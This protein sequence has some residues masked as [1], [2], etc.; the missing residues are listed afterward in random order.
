MFII[1]QQ[2]NVFNPQTLIKSVLFYSVQVWKKNKKL[3]LH[4]N[5]VNSKW[6]WSIFWKKMWASINFQTQ[7]NAL[8]L[9]HVNPGHFGCISKWNYCFVSVWKATYYWF[10]LTNKTS[11]LLVSCRKSNSFFALYHSLPY[12]G[13]AA[14]KWVNL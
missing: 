14:W 8:L 1:Y 9:A 12:H 7:I 5:T 11:I 13:Y 3:F 6:T 4:E 2:Q 10:S